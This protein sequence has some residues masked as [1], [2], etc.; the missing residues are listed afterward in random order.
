[1]IQLQI[2]G[3]SHGPE[4]LPREKVRELLRNAAARIV[5]IGNLNRQLA[6]SSGA[7]IDLCP[8]LS[9]TRDE[10][11]GSLAARNRVR[12]SENLGQNCRVTGDQ[13][14]V[15]CLVMNEIIVNALKYARP[16]EEPVCLTLDCTAKDGAVVVE[17][18]DDGVGLPPD[19]DES[20]HGRV[21][22]KLIRNLVRQIGAEL[23]LH[24]S[25]QGLKFR[26]ALPR[27]SS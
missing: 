20:R 12:I 27:S 24:S 21:G 3:L 9:S 15:L 13:A 26:I 10:L 4:Q 2:D 22:F 16:A 25:G 8:L 11:L 1:M 23:S 6:S 17:L 7:L 18:A 14:S 19:F 5:A